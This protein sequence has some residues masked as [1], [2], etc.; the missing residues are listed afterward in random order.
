VISLDSLDTAAW[1]EIL[2]V[3]PE[4]P[5]GSSIVEHSHVCRAR[6]DTTGVNCVVTP[7]TSDGAP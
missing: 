3:R 1:D 2:A 6:T 4:W 7:T 5:R